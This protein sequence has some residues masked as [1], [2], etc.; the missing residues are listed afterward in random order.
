[1]LSATAAD[2]VELK[3]SNESCGY[4]GNVTIGG[5][6]MFNQLTGYCARDKEFVHLQWKRGEATPDLIKAWDP[7]TGQT[8]ELF[9]C[10]KCSDPVLSI[11]NAKEL[12]H[13]PKCNEATLEAKVAGFAD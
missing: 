6:R 2:I 8:V 3:C 7:K 12:T 1:M 4:K 10:S 5:G 13:C 9:K 11:R